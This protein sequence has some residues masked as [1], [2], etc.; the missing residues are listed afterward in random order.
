[1]DLIKT[2][3][4]LS[5]LIKKWVDSRIDLKNVLT[6]SLA[7]IQ[8]HFAIP[9]RSY[10]CFLRSLALFG[11]IAYWIGVVSDC[12]ILH[13][14]PPHTAFCKCDKSEAKAVLKDSEGK[15]GSPRIKFSFEKIF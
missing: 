11:F 4:S 2:I 3:E 9:V 10:I 5:V 8:R 12:H 15:R 13:A 1:M 14:S 7:V 6:T